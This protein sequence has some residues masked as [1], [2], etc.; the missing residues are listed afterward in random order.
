MITLLITGYWLLLYYF[1]GFR[2]AGVYIHLMNGMGIVM[3]G[4]FAW[5]YFVPWRR[6]RGAVDQGDFPSAAGPLAH[7]RRIVTVNL[8]L[9]LATIITGAGGPWVTAYV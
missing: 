2:E 4:L 9:G 6:F 7:M 5:L 3:M 8:I 1:G